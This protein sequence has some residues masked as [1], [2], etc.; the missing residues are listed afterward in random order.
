MASVHDPRIINRIPYL[1]STIERLAEKQMRNGLHVRFLENCL[2]DNLVPS[3]L[4]LKLKIHIGNDAEAKK[5]Q[6]SIDS[7]L[8]KVSLEI[9]DRLKEEH[10][11]RVMKIRTK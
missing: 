6:E 5:F 2:E 10:Q 4:Q 11:R 3:G 1:K 9:C 7:L 8:G